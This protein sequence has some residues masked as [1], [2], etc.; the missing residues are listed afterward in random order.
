[1]PPQKIVSN[2]HVDFNLY[3]QRKKAPVR[4]MCYRRAQQ[5]ADLGK[6]YEDG[7]MNYA[8]KFRT[9]GYPSFAQADIIIPVELNDTPAD[10]VGKIKTALGQYTATSSATAVPARKI[11][12]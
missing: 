4:E 10:V 6:P 7:L 5:A 3:S 12:Q 2:L 8:R 9:A 11:R 1:M